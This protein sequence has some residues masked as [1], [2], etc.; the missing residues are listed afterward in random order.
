MV[1]VVF[2]FF[3][4]FLIVLMVCNSKGDPCNIGQNIIVVDVIYLMLTRVRSELGSWLGP[5]M[6]VLAP[7]LSVHI[8]SYYQ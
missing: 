4:C 2:Y 5:G 1:F 6:D 8:R 7:W 3:L